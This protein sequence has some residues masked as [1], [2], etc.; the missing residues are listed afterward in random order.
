MN[1]TKRIFSISL[2]FLALAG[3]AH[4]SQFAMVTFLGA[5]TGVNDGSSYV[6]PYEISLNTYPSPTLQLVTC[7]DSL[8]EVSLGDQWT[9]NIETV[10][11]AAASGYFSTR[12]N[13]LAGYEEVAW[14][15]A[16]SY[17]NTDQEVALQH[18]IWDVFGS[19]P[20]D[21]NAAQDTYFA[22][23]TTAAQ[24]AAANSYSGF[25]FSQ[26]VF[27][28]EV[29][30]VSGQPST[31]QAFVYQSATPTTSAQ[32]ISSGGSFTAT[33]EPG[34][35]ILIGSGLFCLLASGAIKRFTAK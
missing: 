15:S 17:A 5:P 11:Q 31:E 33:P 2:L 4:A 34:S 30:A 32:F 3:A 9:A 1:R 18:V 24:A 23:Y 12:N 10:G 26:T 6:T 21:Q 16:Q 13:A 7:Y 14:L 35:L 8:D 19:A 29:G 28:E 22:A 27:L 20:P 25:S